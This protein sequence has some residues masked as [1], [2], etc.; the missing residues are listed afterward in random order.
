ME[1]V[2][3]AFR[4]RLPEPDARC[5]LGEADIILTL[6]MRM[7]TQISQNLFIERLGPREIRN[8]QRNMLQDGFH[9]LIIDPPRRRSIPPEPPP[10]RSRDSPLSRR[11]SKQFPPLYLSIAVKPNAVRGGY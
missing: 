6:A 2:P 3:L 8:V 10:A 7:E 4:F 9:T 11:K 1:F 5:P